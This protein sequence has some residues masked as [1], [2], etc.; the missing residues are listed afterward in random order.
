MSK[1]TGIH[2]ITIPND[3]VWLVEKDGLTLNKECGAVD[4][5]YIIVKND[6]G[7]VIKKY[8]VQGG[9]P[10]PLQFIK[11]GKGAGTFAPLNAEQECA[12]DMLAD[13]D[14]KI[15]VLTGI[16]GTGKTKIAIKFGM[17]KL[18]KGEVE[19]IFLV[20]NP[21]HVG[22]QVGFHKGDKKE[23]VLNWNNPIRDNMEDRIETLEELMEQGKVQIDIPSEMKGRDIKNSWIIVDEAEDLTEELF[24]MLGERVAK[25]SFIVFTGDI[26]QATVG[27]FKT[28]SGLKR[29]YNLRGKINFFGCVELV[30]DVRSEVSK[31]FATLY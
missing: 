2:Y 30:D 29:V 24:K 4:N 16:A 31:A 13:N 5:D 6:E 1:F 25:G 19:T 23:K 21:V 15:K 7:K 3:Q 10:V 22:E 8:R 26:G 9:R 14:I 20:R 28:S 12:F 27:K 11:I 17:E 18:R